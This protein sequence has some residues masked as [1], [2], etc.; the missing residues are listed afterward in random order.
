MGMGSGGSGGSMSEI[1]IT[2]MIDILLVLLIIFM[3]IVP[4]TAMGLGTLIPQPPKKQENQQVNERTIVV[5]VRANGAAAPSYLI[6]QTPVSK[7]DL[8][9]RLADIFSTRQEKVMFIKGDPSLDFGVI[10]QVV[11]MGHQ[12]NVDNI[13]II[14]PRIEAGQ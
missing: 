5:Q 11:N 8:E 10:A 2:P 4:Q 9:P 14:T 1:N 7:Q 12:A 13:G 6:N 3:I